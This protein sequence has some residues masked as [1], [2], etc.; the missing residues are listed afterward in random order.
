MQY[1]IDFSSYSLCTTFIFVTVLPHCP[2]GIHRML[3]LFITSATLILA[4][5]E[6][7]LAGWWVRGGFREDYETWGYRNWALAKWYMTQRKENYKRHQRLVVP[8]IAEVHTKFWRMIYN[9]IHPLVHIKA[10]T[11]SD[12]RFNPQDQS[13]RQTPFCSSD[14]QNGNNYNCFTSEWHSTYLHTVNSQ[15]NQQKTNPFK[16]NLRCLNFFEYP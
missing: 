11:L 16:N 8:H 14:L 15:L 7:E 4:I 13:A 6:H 9:T 2:P 5:Q 12:K 3:F 10:M 1:C